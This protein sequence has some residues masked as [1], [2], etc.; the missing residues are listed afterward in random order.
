MS[1]IE[2]ISAKNYKG[3][4]NLELSI[5]PITVLLGSNSCGKSS[6]INLLL[7]LTQSIDTQEEL[8]SPLRI[9]GPL[10]GLGEPDNIIRDRNEEN[11]LEITIKIK[12]DDN[13][14]SIEN[15]D[16]SLGFTKDEFIT[17]VDHFTN[18]IF[19][20]NKKSL[21]IQFQQAQMGHNEDIFEVSNR[22]LY[23]YITSNIRKIRNYEY[24]NK[25][26]YSHKGVKDYFV[27]STFQR[28]LDALDIFDAVEIKSIRPKSYNYTISLNKESKNKLSILS[29]K[30]I[31]EAGEAILHFRRPN[32]RGTFE[33]TS[34]VIDNK[35]L[36]NSKK[37]IL[38]N[39]NI[40]SLV[41]SKKLNERHFYYTSFHVLS[42]NPAATII[43]KIIDQCSYQLQD[44]INKST[45]LHVSPLRA[46]P[47]R[48]YLLDKTIL[49]TELDTSNGTE[50][51]EILKRNQ[52]ILTRINNLLQDFNLV[53]KVDNINDVIHKIT[54]VQDGVD[55]EI[56]DVG[57]GI[58][59]VIPILVQAF[60]SPPGSITI[61]E[62]PEIH[63]HPR[64]Q[65][66]LVDALIEESLSSNKRFVIETHSEAIIRRIRRRVVESTYSIKE[67]D[68]IIYDIQK[69]E[70]NCS[71]LQEIELKANGDIAWPDGFLDVEIEDLQSIQI[72]KRNMALKERAEQERI[73]LLAKDGRL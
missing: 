3:F 64:M 60:I 6:I 53:M 71:F 24:S 33:I 32:L 10:V 54:V 17:Y 21:E 69:D 28:T 18:R 35:I 43:A 65:A 1:K 20:E 22:K 49:R 30:I 23:S 44:A 67:S 47:Q 63:L 34:D 15:I 66:W 4:G 8:L 45:I 42:K 51:A 72:A 38:E 31:N 58:S 13:P 2:S 61:I 59:Q 39:I 36:K 9:N 11:I 52:P 68:V 16:Y 27:S 41:P 55:L 70:K 40:N 12:N 73:S 29:L 56:T 50:L 25:I 48:Y 5:K 26:Q 57:F 7:M 14:H 62:Q 46:F 37:D 19:S